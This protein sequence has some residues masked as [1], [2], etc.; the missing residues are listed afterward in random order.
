M[1]KIATYFSLPRID[2]MFLARVGLKDKYSNGMGKYISK[3]M[4]YE[5]ISH[6]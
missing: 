1:S 4:E 6:L 2:P 3:S 5:V